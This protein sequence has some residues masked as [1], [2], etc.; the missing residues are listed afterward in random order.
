MERAS[1]RRSGSA[2]LAA[3]GLAPSASAWTWPLGGRCSV[4]T[5]SAPMRTRPGSIAVSTSPG[6]SG[7]PVRA[8]A[9]GTVSFAGV[10]PAS[11]RT[12]TIQVDGY[13]VSLTHLGEIS[14]AKGA[15]VAEGDTVGVAGPSGEAEWPT[16]YV[17]LGIRVSAA[18]DGYV[19]P[20]TLL[21]PRAV[22]PPPVG[23][24]ARRRSRPRAGAG[25][26]RPL[27]H[28][29]AGVAVAPAPTPIA[30]TPAAGSADGTGCP[31]HRAASGSGRS[32]SP[33]IAPA[34]TRTPPMR[35]PEPSRRP[36]ATPAAAV[37]LP[38]RRARR[39][40]LRPR[41]PHAAP[42]R[43]DHSV[44]RRRRRAR[45]VGHRRSGVPRSRRRRLAVRSP[46]CPRRRRRRRAAP[47]RRSTARQA[48][49][50]AVARRAGPSR[51][52]PARRRRP[53][54]QR[55]RA[56]GMRPRARRAAGASAARWQRARARRRSR[57]RS[58]ARALPRR[59]SGARGGCWRA[60]VESMAMERYY[61]T[62][63]IYY[64][65]ST[66]HIGHAYTTIAADILARNRRQR[67]AE[68]FFLTGVDEHAAKVA[69]VAAEQGLSPQEYADQIAVVWRELPRAPQR[70]E[71][72]LHPH[73]RRGAQALRPGIP[74]AAL[75]QR[76][77]LPG[78]LRGAL[79]RRLRGVQDGG[80]PRRRQVPGARP[81]AR[82]D[83][84]AQLVL[85]ALVVPAAAARAVRAR[86]LR[87]AGVPGQRGAELHRG[88]AAG[89]LD[90]PG[91]PD[92]GDPDP[93]GSGFDRLRL[94]GRPRQL[95]ERA[96]VRASGRGSGRD[97]L[98]VRAASARQGH[99][100]LPLRLLAGD[101]ARGR[102]R[103]ARGSCSST[104]TCCST[105]GRSRSR[106]GT[107]STRST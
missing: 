16:P 72:L 57:A 32:W 92:L 21:P 73:E 24:R 5:R 96:H 101:A 65:N 74:A 94:G 55:V 45:A 9:A 40:A 60:A 58:R 67:G 75:R 11:G 85:P 68:T 106:S 104:G 93:V 88:R 26:R 51:R 33:R 86:R 48:S 61:V 42:A 35:R 29:A 34:A 77:R 19:D 49:G 31:V 17:H 89:L 103:A 105:T 78:R 82:V 27:L 81:G 2:L 6:S 3:L 79:L 50:A 37:A 71:R 12:V 47:Q 99:P 8:P 102:V 70:V 15:T 38:Q 7:E 107:S 59:R 66:P 100:P 10:V 30:G 62:T 14:V 56:C 91:R 28:R 1:S 18:A 4:P 95:P 97:V 23:R 43:G 13:A 80:G 64:V 54:A 83:R 84:G 44:L 20:A 90:Q 25:Q 39:V 76:A 87:P 69:R 41:V 36:S 98:A 22:V 46:A 63:P 52:A 53:V